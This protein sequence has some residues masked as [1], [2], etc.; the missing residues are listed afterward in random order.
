MSDDRQ[1]WI[2]FLDDAIGDSD[3]VI[4]SP[5]STLAYRCELLLLYEME[6][7]TDPRAA[8]VYYNAFQICITHSSQAQAGVFAQKAYETRLGLEGEDSPDTQR[9]KSFMANPADHMSFGI[10]QSWERL[11]GE[12]P[13]NLH[14]Q[15]FDL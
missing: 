8:R 13:K 5:T 1:R 2:Q 12:V 6:A 3:H 11:N 10:S 14:A 7:I 4:E 9:T 15:E